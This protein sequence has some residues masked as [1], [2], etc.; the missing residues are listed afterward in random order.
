MSARETPARAKL[1]TMTEEELG[2]D[3]NPGPCRSRPSRL[4]RELAVQRVARARER[5]LALD[6]AIAC[7]L[8]NSGFDDVVIVERLRALRDQHE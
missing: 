5:R 1:E 2:T 7:F 3:Q 4:V 6:E 8:T